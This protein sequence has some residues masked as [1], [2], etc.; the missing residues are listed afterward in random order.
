MCVPMDTCVHSIKVFTTTYI[1]HLTS[2]LICGKYGFPCGGRHNP[3]GRSPPTGDRQHASWGLADRGR[4]I[5]CTTGGSS[6][7]ILVTQD[8]RG[9]LPFGDVDFRNGAPPFP[10]LPVKQ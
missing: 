10:L 2:T 5:G 7:F 1:C 3:P 6:H 4:R 8:H 9:V